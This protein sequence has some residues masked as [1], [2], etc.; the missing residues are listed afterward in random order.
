MVGQLLPLLHR[1]SGFQPFLLV[2]LFGVWV[3]APFM[4]RKVD[5]S[6]TVARPIQISR[7]DQATS[8][9]ARGAASR[10]K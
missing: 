4:A 10:C 8:M 2:L 5:Q 3:D 1:I 6:F 7:F 9:M